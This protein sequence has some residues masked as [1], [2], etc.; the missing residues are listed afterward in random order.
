MMINKLFEIIKLVLDFF[1]NKKDREKLE[2]INKIE[3]KQK[4]VEFKSEIEKIAS[5]IESKD[6]EIKKKALEDMRKLIAE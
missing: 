2:V 1:F 4:E 3:E 6:S 5:N